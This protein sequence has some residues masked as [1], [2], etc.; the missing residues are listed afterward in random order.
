ML[1]E[2]LTKKLLRKQ[3]EHDLLFSQLSSD[4]DDLEEL[5]EDEE[6]KNST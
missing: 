6:V 3:S 5:L 2:I 4:E 1:R